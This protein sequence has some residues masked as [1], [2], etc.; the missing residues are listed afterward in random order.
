[1]SYVAN[2]ETQEDIKNIECLLDN[3]YTLKPMIGN[4]THVL[5]E[6]LVVD[7]I[8]NSIFVGKYLDLLDLGTNVPVRTSELLCKLDIT[9]E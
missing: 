8:S 5:K 2:I 7:V 6:G 4:K 1:M 3:G 9:K